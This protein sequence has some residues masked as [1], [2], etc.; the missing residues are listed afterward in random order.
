LQVRELN[1]TLRTPSLSNP[2]GA[3]II[4]DLHD[5]PWRIHHKEAALSVVG[6]LGLA[7]GAEHPEELPPN[8]LKLSLGAR[9][10][11]HSV[12]ALP[13]VSVDPVADRA[14]HLDRTDSATLPVEHQGR[15]GD[16]INS[17]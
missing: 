12:E 8:I 1:T 2:A 3:G 11:T 6:E 13:G 9:R 16:R 4:A 15:G 17:N 7:F 5:S 10:R 14:T